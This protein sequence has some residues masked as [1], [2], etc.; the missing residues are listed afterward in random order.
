M[1]Q[2]TWYLIAIGLETVALLILLV[3]QAYHKV[4]IQELMDR[5]MMIAEAFNH[6]HKEVK[7]VK[8]QERERS[9]A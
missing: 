3:R 1:D 4:A 6:L 8:E 2:M 7:E 5:T 9:D